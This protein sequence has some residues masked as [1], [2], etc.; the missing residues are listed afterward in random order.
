MINWS[1]RWKNKNFWVAL[2]P[3]ILLLIQV[4][5]AVFGVEIDF[6]V[7]SGKL[8]AVV[9]AVFVVLTILG[10]VTDPTTEGIADS[11]QA[12]SY[13]IP[14]TKEGLTKKEEA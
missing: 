12:M 2:I 3:A 4:V 10:I 14:K 6:G 1:I 11:A 8:L 7:L 13:E 9:D 5:L